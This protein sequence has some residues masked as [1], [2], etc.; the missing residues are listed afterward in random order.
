M[1]NARNLRESN[2]ETKIHT[3]SYFKYLSR[4]DI[5]FFTVIKSLSTGYLMQVTNLKYLIC[6]DLK[7][8][9]SCYL[10][11]RYSENISILGNPKY[12]I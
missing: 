3:N 1:Y 4:K 8:I 2:I 7:A 12:L 10:Q 5:L 11:F 9:T 6:F